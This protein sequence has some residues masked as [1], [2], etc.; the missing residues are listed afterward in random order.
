MESAKGPSDILQSEDW[1]V[2]VVFCWIRA[3]SRLACQAVA[4]FLLGSVVQS[5]RTNASSGPH[6]A[7]PVCVCVGGRQGLYMWCC[8]CEHGS[9]Q[10][11]AN[12]RHGVMC[13]RVF[14][15]WWPFGGP[16]VVH[17]LFPVSFYMSLN[18]M[19]MQMLYKFWFSRGPCSLPFWLSRTGEQGLDFPL[20]CIH[21]A[22]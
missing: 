3:L 7:T 15:C 9:G 1:N 4:L 13:G 16:M 18:P 17:E 22:P 21:L 12:S 20:Y 10:A 6:A 8:T 14:L 19:S 5:C 2:P 11:V